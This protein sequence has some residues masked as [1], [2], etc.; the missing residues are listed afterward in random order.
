M[1]HGC[2]DLIRASRRAKLAYAQDKQPYLVSIHYDS[3]RNFIR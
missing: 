3:A 2:I 1:T